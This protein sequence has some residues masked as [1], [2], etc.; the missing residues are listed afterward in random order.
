MHWFYK[1]WYRAGFMTS[2]VIMMLFYYGYS[3]R[4]PQEIHIFGIPILRHLII[5]CFWIVFLSILASKWLWQRV[6]PHVITNFLNIS[7][8]LAVLYALY[9]LAA[10]L[11]ASSHDPLINWS[12]PL[13]TSEDTEQ[14]AE[15]YRPDIYYI[16]L[17][18]YARADVLQEI[19]NYDNSGFLDN[20]R[21]R[22]FYVAENSYTNYN[23]TDLSLASSLN[24][25][26][27]D[28]LAFAKDVNTNREPIMNLMLNSRVRSWLEEDGY[29]IYLSGEYIFAEES[30]PAL[31]FS[32]SE[33]QRLT[34]FE[35]LL[36]EST[37]FE[38][39]IDLGHVNISNYTYQ[40]HR[41]KILNGFAD[42]VNLVNKKGPK[43]V[44]AHIIAPHPPFVFDQDGNS[45]QPDWE[46]KIFDDRQLTGG[47]ESYIEGYRE[48]LQ[49]INGLVIKTIDNILQHSTAPPII[50][51]QADHGPASLLDSTTNTSCLKERY[52]ILNAYYFP[53]GHD[54]ALYSTITPVNT[55]RIIFDSYFGTDLEILTDLNYFSI[56]KDP[57]RFTEVTNQVDTT[58]DISAYLR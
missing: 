56:P 23:Q 49:Y 42:T 47:F 37:M 19:Y 8:G 20:L 26:Y 36:L 38:I 48:E 33:I 11:F 17:D 44:F 6:R 30:D 51:L 41:E 45:V 4:L 25:E 12:R 9:L 29:Q 35:S 57:Y 32:V 18:G 10:Y 27:L 15:T 39:L 14:L 28:Y 2:I 24:F 7:S 52:S 16:I 3:Y 1:D 40:T 34:T 46:Y 13:N 5:L 58:C 22:G 21:T 53:D 31:V 43:F 54:E 55:F 50:I